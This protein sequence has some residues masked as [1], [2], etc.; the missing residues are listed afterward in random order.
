LAGYY[1]TGG[2]DRAMRM[3]LWTLILAG[4]LFFG[5]LNFLSTYR[6]GPPGAFTPP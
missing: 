2:S 4:V 5:A 1:T 6:P 3:R